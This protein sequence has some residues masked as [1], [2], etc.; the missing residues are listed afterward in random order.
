MVLALMPVC[1]MSQK[2]SE[3]IQVNDAIRGRRV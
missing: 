2:I 1:K 3:C